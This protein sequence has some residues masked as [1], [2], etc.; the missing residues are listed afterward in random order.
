MAFMDDPNQPLSETAFALFDVETTGLNPA[1]GHRV[2]E[3]ACLRVR[4][5]Q[6]IA[7]FESLVDPERT[8]S[9]GAFHVNHITPEML[10]GAPHFK[11]IAALLLAVMENAVLVA[12]NAS[13]DLGFLASELEI[14]GLPPPEGAIVD[15]LTLVRRL[16]HFASNSLPSVA[17]TMGIETG[18]AHRAMGDVRTTRYVL[19]RILYD[20][21]SRWGAATLGDLVAFQGGPIPY[22]NPYAVPLPPTIAEALDSGGQVRVRYVNAFGQETDR[23]IRPLRV[24]E[25]HGYLYLVAHCYLKGEQRTFR[26]DRIIEMVLEP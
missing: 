8:I 1:Y 5:G 26:L 7:A 24:Q 9:E 18:P 12:H 14:A 3:V 13:F 15:T 19:E 6:E 4:D 17:A 16:Y 2:C 25:Y 11:E 21:Q 22:P 23:I 10:V 20:L